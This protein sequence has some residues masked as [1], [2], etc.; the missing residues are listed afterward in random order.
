VLVPT[1]KNEDGYQLARWTEPTEPEDEDDE[2]DDQDEDEEG[3]LEADKELS[4]VP[5]FELM[6]AA[7][8]REAV[9]MIAGC[10]ESATAA[11]SKEPEVIDVHGDEEST[12]VRAGPAEM[13]LD[14]N[15]IAIG[16]R[17]AR[18]AGALKI[19]FQH[20][21]LDMVRRALRPDATG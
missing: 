16:A 17:G 11:T 20:P 21:L 7:N 19:G 5:H 10:D 15:G 1:W 6:P 12:S 13:R 18:G 8:A 4:R 14:K 2:D 9:A 3:E